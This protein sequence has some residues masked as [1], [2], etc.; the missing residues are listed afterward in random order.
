MIRYKKRHKWPE[1]K[2][3][4]SSRKDWRALPRADG[5]WAG[6]ASLTRGVPHTGSTPGSTHKDGQGGAKGQ[7]GQ[8]KGEEGA[9]RVLPL[10]SGILETTNNQQS[11]ETY[12]PI[13]FS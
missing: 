2:V 3:V 10:R 12:R 7:G 4:N 11:T 8:E 5:A 1:E 13:P 6:S 9:F